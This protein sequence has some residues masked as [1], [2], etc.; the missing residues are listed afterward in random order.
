MNRLTTDT[1]NGSFET[2]L[3]F[4]YGKDGWAYIRHDGEHEG[5]K[6]TDWAKRQCLLRGCDEAFTEAPEE[7]DQRLCD[8]MMEAPI[9]PIA[10]A[11]C[12]ASQTV[13]LRSRLKMYEDTSRTPEE[14]ITLITEHRLAMERL[15]R[16]EALPLPPPNDPLTLEEL[17]EMD[18]EPVWV[19]EINGYPPRWGLV[20]WCKKNKRDV[21]YVTINNG[22]SIDAKTF[23]AA[24]GK[25]YR[26]KTEEGTSVGS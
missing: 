19:V 6:L 16:Y 1:P 11:Y 26:R 25:I 8:C 9:C 12:F 13:H 17:R 22:V 21:V 20:Y 3:N 18:G 15:S 24:G 2:M 5:V 7:I 14:V 10:L 4:V 23:M